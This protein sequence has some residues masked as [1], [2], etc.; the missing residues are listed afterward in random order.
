[1][2]ASLISVNY[3]TIME[4]A[5]QCKMTLIPVTPTYYHYIESNFGSRKVIV[6]NNNIWRT[7]LAPKF[8]S[9][10]KD[11]NLH[12]FHHLSIKQFLEVYSIDI[13][14]FHDTIY[15]GFLSAGY[16]NCKDFYSY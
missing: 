13:Q 1:I 3:R 14:E 12:K 4:Y 6:D 10:L 7:K 8:K 2:G 9:I 5:N 16:N 15:Q 11:K